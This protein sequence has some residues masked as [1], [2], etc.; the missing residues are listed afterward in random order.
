[1]K[2]SGLKRSVYFY[3]AVGATAIVLIV[4]AR[5]YASGSQEA[6]AKQREAGLAETQRQQAEVERVKVF[7][8][9]PMAIEDVL[10]MPGTVEA[11]EDIDL[12]APTGGTVA[13]IGVK[14]GDRIEAG[15]ALLKL[16]MGQ[17][18]AV[19]REAQTNL[20][21]AEGNREDMVKLFESNIISRSER[22]EAIGLA[23]RARALA[24]AQEARVNDG[25]IDAPISGVVDRLTVDEGEHINPGQTVMK[26]VDVDRIKVVLNVPEKDIHQIRTG[27]PVRLSTQ[28]AG[29]TYDFQGTIDYVAMTADPVSRT[30]P[31]KVVAENP[32]HRLRPGMIVSARLVRRSL[33]DALALPFFSVMDRDDISVVFVVEEGVARQRRVETGAI[34]G[35]IVEVASGV[36]AGEAVVIVGQRALVD[37]EAVE[38]V[39]DLTEPAKRL[40]EQGGDVSHLSM[41]LGH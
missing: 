16:D 1:M 13:W 12:A 7:R 25:R 24:E 21:L 11:F 34:Q 5:L 39:E 32:E 23:L 30:Y 35:G 41:E 36:A 3:G 20:A 31:V 37:G 15:R 27:Q 18:E 26:I 4:A 2:R 19:L 9:F 33:P 8:P 17:Q 22:D 40:L 38:I 28:E 10:T 29:A 14:E 6:R